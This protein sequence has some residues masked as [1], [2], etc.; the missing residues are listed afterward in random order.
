VTTIERCQEC[1]FDGGDWTDETSLAAVAGLPPRWRRAIAGLDA[2]RLRRRPLPGTWSIAEYTDHVRET[3]FGMRFVLDVALADPGTDLGPPP[4][5]RFDP[6]P[7]PIDADAALA[8]LAREVDALCDRLRELPAERW[9]DEVTVGG[10]AIDAHWIVRHALHDV[11][12]HLG[13]VDRLRA[14]LR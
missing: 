4:E 14:A 7:R 5:N 9:Q 11:T 13:D 6:D 10:E 8:G 12:H 2:D 1:G 3:I